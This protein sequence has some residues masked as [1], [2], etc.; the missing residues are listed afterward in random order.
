MGASTVV[1]KRSPKKTRRRPRLQKEGQAVFEEAL[2]E[3]ERERLSDVINRLIAVNFLVRDKERERYAIIRRERDR[4][5]RFFRFLGWDFIIDESHEVV[6]V[7]PP[8]A[9]LRRNFNRE[10]TIWLLILRLIYEEKR[11]ALLLSRQPVVTLAEIRAKYETFRLP[12]P[13]R[14]ALERLVRLVRG[15][16]LLD[17]L[18]GEGLTD[19]SRYV[20]HHT[21][22][23]AVD[24][25]EILALQEKIARF[26]QSTDR[27]GETG[28]G[29]DEED[30]ADRAE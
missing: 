7:A 22:L 27:E 4:L 3:R 25:Q 14:T 6:F 24:T 18:D 28:E 5:E 1:R 21:W 8:G 30:A 17:P 20:L 9:A 26:S 23:Y 12:L 2:G 13:G 29:D 15:Y 16:Q 19:D 11:H 10:E